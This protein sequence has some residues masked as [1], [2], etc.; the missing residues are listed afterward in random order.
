MTHKPH[1]G[2][3]YF[4]A[5]GDALGTEYLRYS[6]TKGTRQE[7]DFLIKHQ[8]MRSGQRVL[9]VGCGP[10]RHALELARRGMSVVGIDI[11]ER[12]VE[13]ATQSAREE[14]LDAR[15][16]VMDA[17]EL[18]FREEFDHA[19]S[20][21]Q[22]AFGLMGSDDPVIFR[23][24]VD[25]LKPGGRLAV[26][27]FSALFEAATRRP[28]ANFDIEHG[29][30]H[31]R[32]VISA[33]EGGEQEVEAWTGVYT[34]RELTLMAEAVYLEVL[35]VYSVDPGDYRRRKPAIDHPEFLLLARKPAPFNR[36]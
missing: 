25:A 5:L 16:H 32:M 36:R 30:V 29:I 1:P 12:F 26:T 18:P 20:L 28:E 35:A 33:E 21:C 9:D 24:L 8:G 14:E 22:G 10:G 23:G 27:A 6:F 15:F 2:E 34:P 13:I 4:A 3:P 11:S 19:L 31:E 17:R 7:V